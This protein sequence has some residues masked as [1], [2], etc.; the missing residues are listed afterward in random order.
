[1]APAPGVGSEI[2]QF[3]SPWRAGGSSGGLGGSTCHPCFSLC[4]A[5]GW[6]SHCWGDWESAGRRSRERGGVCGLQGIPSFQSL[7]SAPSL[8]LLCFSGS[9]LRSPGQHRH[10]W[11]ILLGPGLPCSRA[12]APRLPHLSPQQAEP[13]QPDPIWVKEPKTRLR[14]SQGRGKILSGT[15]VT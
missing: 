11:G 8:P 7:S 4:Q 2:D 12:T 13:P 9:I 3:G 5:W 10:G 15:V 1:M 6:R 14:L